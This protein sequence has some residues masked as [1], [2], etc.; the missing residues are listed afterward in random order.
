MQYIK[1]KAPVPAISSIGNIR[2]R[3]IIVERDRVVTC[4]GMAKDFF[5]GHNR[6]ANPLHYSTITL[7]LQGRVTL[8][9]V[10]T[11]LD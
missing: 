6:V 7:I 9:M 8:N 11:F 4:H 2:L 5:K 1:L 3:T 10:T